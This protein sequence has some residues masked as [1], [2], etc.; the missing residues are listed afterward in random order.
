[1]N[2]D[3]FTIDGMTYKLRCKDCG[4][5]W[6]DSD[7]SIPTCPVCNNNKR[8]R[9]LLADELKSQ[10]LMRNTNVL[11]S[12]PPSNTLQQVD[13]NLF[14]VEE[15]YKEKKTLDKLS[16]EER[17]ELIDALIMIVCGL[18]YLLVLSKLPEWMSNLCLVGLVTLSYCVN[19]VT[20]LQS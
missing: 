19:K 9:Q 12:I 7:G 13:N 6:T 10:I 16:D 15:K 18:L 20:L 11:L 3:F 1:M 5:E 2:V 4:F 14:Y 17:T 8:N